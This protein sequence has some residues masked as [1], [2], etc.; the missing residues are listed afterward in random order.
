MISEQI[1]ESIYGIF[2]IDIRVS[3]LVKKVFDEFK[4]EVC[5]EGD[6]Q[7]EYIAY[8]VYNDVITNWVEESWVTDIAQTCLESDGQ[9]HNS[10]DYTTELF[11]PQVHS[12]VERSIAHSRTSSYPSTE[13]DLIVQKEYVFLDSEEITVDRKYEFRPIQLIELELIH[14]LQQYYLKL[15]E[16]F[17]HTFEGI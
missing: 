7:A 12:P 10:V 4:Q 8:Q 2:A 13:L 17:Q 3:I 14:A 11:T 16:M 6:K 15:P 9:H 5:Q 1:A